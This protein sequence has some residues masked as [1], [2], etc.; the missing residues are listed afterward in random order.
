M[1]KPEWLVDGLVQTKSVV[2]LYGPSGSGKS[3]IAID[4]ALSVAY[5]IE[6]QQRAVKP[7]YVLYVSAE[8]TAGLGQRVRAWIDHQGVSPAAADIA[9]LPEAVMVTDES[10]HLDQ[11][12]ERLDSLDEAPI[13]VIIDTLARCFQG[14]ENETRDMGLFI[15]GVDR[16]KTQ[17]GSTVVAVHHTNKTG[18]DER[19]SGALRAA[20]D[21]MI[22]CHEGHTI[23]VNAQ[24]GKGL[25]TLEV[26]KQ[27]DSIGGQYGLGQLVDVGPS[28]VPVV[29]WH[30]AQ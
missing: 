30:E 16:I 23:G 10:E 18:S 22:S 15:R 20:T 13:L 5:G 14:D 7:G 19:G 27:K 28:A 9:W 25:F 12:F 3:F 24:K 1:P 21:T 4:L 17:Y 11:L 6:W 8:G 2:G 29:V 26:S